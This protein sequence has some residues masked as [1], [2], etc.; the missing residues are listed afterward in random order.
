[1]G[2]GVG[3][4]FGGR[5]GAGSGS[6]GGG[7]GGSRCGRY[8]GWLRLVCWFTG[9]FY[10]FAHGLMTSQGDAVRLCP[11]CCAGGRRF[12]CWCWCRRRVLYLS[13]RG[14]NFLTKCWHARLAHW[15]TSAAAGFRVHNRA[16]V[17]VTAHALRWRQSS[18][19]VGTSRPPAGA[20]QR[21]G[22]PRVLLSGGGPG[23]VGSLSAVACVA[24]V[25]GGRCLWSPRFWAPRHVVALRNQ[26]GSVASS[27]ITVAVVRLRPA[28]H[29]QTGQVGFARR[30]GEG[31]RTNTPHGPVGHGHRVAG[32]AV[33]AATAP[34]SQP[35]AAIP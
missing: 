2:V 16:Q 6:G 4:G 9:D 12:W 19:V 35:R 3:V 26:P 29:H 18:C 30:R 34:R 17:R 28:G 21:G 5:F 20:L 24:L 15:V 23:L 33:R 1:M 14:D 8:V 7:G 22:D 11:A 13:I 10:G 25:G 32:C 31:P 27:R